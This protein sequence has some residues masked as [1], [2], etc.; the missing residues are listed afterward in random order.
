VPWRKKTPSQTGKI[1][2]KTKSYT[3]DAELGRLQVDQFEVRAGSE[4]V[5]ATGKE[6]FPETGP[7]EAFKSS[8]LRELLLLFSIDESFRKGT[9][10]LNRVLLRKEEKAIQFRTLAN[11][12]EREGKYISEQRSKKAEEILAR[13]GFDAEGKKIPDDKGYIGGN[14]HGSLTEE[15]QSKTMKDHRIAIKSTNAEENGCP[16]NE[17]SGGEGLSSCLPNDLIKNAI[18]EL[19]DG[20]HK[21]LQISLLELQDTFEDTKC[22]KANISLDDV[23]SKKQK[24][25]QRKKNAPGKEKREFVKNTVAHLKNGKNESYILNAPCVEKTLI[26][27]LAFLLQNGLLDKA[28]Q[29]I[30]FSDGAADL[31]LAIQSLF[32]GLFPFKIILD[33]FHLEKKCKERLSMAMREKP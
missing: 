2:E 15:F 17:G 5:F 28:G 9:D 16:S 32:L 24:E 10:K 7:R 20:K 33:W 3:I 30:F 11:I 18:D 25:G 21:E 23:L 26:L 31:R 22:I 27:V 14:E 19:N 8:R 4:K 29:L 6:V 1:V 12:V 13:Y